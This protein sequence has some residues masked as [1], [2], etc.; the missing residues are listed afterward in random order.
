MIDAI[1]KKIRASKDRGTARTALMAKPFEFSEIQAN[2]IL[3]MMLGRLTQLGQRGARQ[4]KEG[5]RGTIREFEAILAE[6]D[7]LMGVDPRRAGR[8]ARRVQGDRAEPRSSA[9]TPA[10]ISVVELVEDEPFVV[11]VTA[12]GYVQAVPERALRRQGRRPG[13][14]DAVAQVIDT[15]AL[16]GCCSSPARG[17]AY[18][19][20]CTTCPRSGSPRRRTS[21]SSPTASR[22]WP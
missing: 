8:G 16:A 13:R 11:T 17:R 20:P 6:R 2:H 12:R 1:I 10:T 18:R 15:T 21:S 5:A 19:A 7:M 9:T 4:G 3:D 22:W 14:A